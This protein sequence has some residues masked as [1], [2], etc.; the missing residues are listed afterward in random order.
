MTAIRIPWY[1]GAQIISH[2]P[3]T[4]NGQRSVLGQRPCQILA[5]GAGGNGSLLR[6][7]VDDAGGGDIPDGGSQHRSSRL[8][9]R[10]RDISG[11]LVD[12]TGHTA[13][14][15]T[16]TEVGHRGVSRLRI[17]ANG[18][19][20]TGCTGDF[21]FTEQNA[22]EGCF[23]LQ[24]NAGGERRISGIFNHQRQLQARLCNIFCPPLACSNASG[25]LHIV[26]GE[27]KRGPGICCIVE[28]IA[29]FLLRC[30]GITEL[31]TGLESH[32]PGI[33]NCNCLTFQD[34]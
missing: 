26:Y 5:A 29:A 17:G 7:N 28:Y 1:F 13:V 21:L 32:F 18:E 12:N 10:K 4:G 19:R 25:I 23:L 22:A 14:V 11:L 24:S 27:L 30:K 15:N 20:R 33:S 31:L 9:T 16:P 2:I 6:H 8:F 34:G 3:R